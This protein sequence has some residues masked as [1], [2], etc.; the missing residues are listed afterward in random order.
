MACDCGNTGYTT[1]N[2]FDPSC[3]D[4]NCGSNVNPNCCTES[5]PNCCEICNCL[6]FT[7]GND[8]ILISKTTCNFDIRV[9]PN[10]LQNLLD[11]PSSSCITIV[12]EVINGQLVFT[13]TLNIACVEA[14]IPVIPVIPD[15]PVYTADNGIDITAYN[16]ELGGGDAKSLLHN[17]L[18]SLGGPTSPYSLTTYQKDVSGSTNITENVIGNNGV[19]NLSQTTIKS[20]IT[21]TDTETIVKQGVDAFTSSIQT[22][23]N[24]ETDI[25][26]LALGYINSNI[27][28]TEFGFNYPITV[29]P[30]THSTP[31]PDNETSVLCTASSGLFAVSGKAISLT[32]NSVN[33]DISLNVPQGYLSLYSVNGSPKIEI[34]AYD[35]N[36][37]VNPMFIS[38]T[39]PGSYTAE[40]DLYN[41]RGVGAYYA[42]SALKL[43]DYSA[44]LGVKLGNAT[45]SVYTP[46]AN[47]N[48]ETS[49]FNSSTGLATVAAK[50]VSLVSNSATYSQ[51]NQTVPNAS[52]ALASINGSSTYAMQLYTPSG[53]SQVVSLGFIRPGLIDF[54][55]IFVADRISGSFYAQTIM[56]GNGVGPTAFSIIG[57]YVPNSLDL[58][59]YPKPVVDLNLTSYTNY[60]QGLISMFAKATYMSG[61]VCI[62]DISVSPPGDPDGIAECASLEI[63]SVEGGLLLPRVTTAQRLAIASPTGGLQVFDYEQNAVMTYSNTAW[64]GFRYIGSYFQGYTGSSWVNLN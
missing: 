45:S 12:K 59:L 14:L 27:S 21:P 60:Q 48:E 40:V 2:C 33:A 52:V 41:E 63:R 35:P 31:S 1:Q 62:S 15:V 64:T 4:P 13:P 46:P 54:E 44:T 20:G 58:S 32:S 34:V 16:I 19:E 49:Y 56:S 24:V 57:A 18:L 38:E 61:K 37:L 53:G 9:S 3:G 17:T 28:K 6:Q 25:A 47:D 26:Y 5:N 7:S 39:S 30:I 55:N 50:T 8:T 43:A 11:I 42:H 10:L 23:E 51:I 36:T 22:V 29:D